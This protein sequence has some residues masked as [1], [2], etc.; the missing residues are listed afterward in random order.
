[1]R[2]SGCGV[3]WTEF[4]GLSSVAALLCS[5]LLL[6]VSQVGLRASDSA[7]EWTETFRELRRIEDVAKSETVVE[8]DGRL[9]AI[10]IR[11][12]AAPESRR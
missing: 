6:G 10:P 11:T 3:T 1:M 9:Y 5:I 7:G 4:L 8:L 2:R 12:D